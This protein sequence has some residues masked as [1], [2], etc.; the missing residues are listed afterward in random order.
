MMKCRTYGSSCAL[1][2]LV[3]PGA[4]MGSPQVIAYTSPLCTMFLRNRCRRGHLDVS[5]SHAT[6][7]RGELCS[8]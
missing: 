8:C 3:P 2:M 6:C 1:S 5:P 4:P 7:Y